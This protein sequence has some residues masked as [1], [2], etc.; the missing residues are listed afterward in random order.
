M[1]TATVEKFKNLVLDLDLPQTDVV[2]FGVTCPYCGK[3]DRI[4][5]LEPPDEVALESGSLNDYREFWALLAAEAAD[6]EPAVCKFCRNI[7]LLDEHRKARPL[8]D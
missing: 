8:P 4:R 5:P 1:D 6:G 3:N 7:L 2:L